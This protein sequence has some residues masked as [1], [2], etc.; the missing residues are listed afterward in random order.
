MVELKNFLKEF[1]LILVKLKLVLNVLVVKIFVVSGK[2]VVGKTLL[3][4]LDELIW[5]T[6]FTRLLNLFVKGVVVRLV[7]FV[8]EEVVVFSCFLVVSKLSKYFCQKI[9]I[10]L[11]NPPSVMLA[12]Y[13]SLLKFFNFVFLCMFL[14]L[15][16]G[17]KI[18]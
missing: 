15:K 11:L 10:H 2:L 13:C 5:E 3:E 8:R 6:V 1:V 12:L 9:S 16:P 7:K 18:L 17:S 14:V 4:I